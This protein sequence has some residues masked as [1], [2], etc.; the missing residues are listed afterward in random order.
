MTLEHPFNDYTHIFK[1]RLFNGY[2]IIGH[3][4][5]AINLDKKNG[6]ISVNNEPKTSKSMYIPIFSMS[7]F[8]MVMTS[9]V[10]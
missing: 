10:T 6:N 4:M 9:L 2:N 7:S 5:S 8:S 1:V 3:V